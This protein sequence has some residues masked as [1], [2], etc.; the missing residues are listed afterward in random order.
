MSGP[1][2]GTGSGLHSAGAGDG[3]DLVTAAV[4]SD[5]APPAP[6]TEIE[7]TPLTGADSAPG[8]DGN[9]DQVGRGI[10]RFGRGGVETLVTEW[11]QPLKAFLF[12]RKTEVRGTSGS[13]K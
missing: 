7:A 10:V 2:G 9:Q 3:R 4:T 5:R 13:W 6:Q 1:D 11:A 12:T 8:S